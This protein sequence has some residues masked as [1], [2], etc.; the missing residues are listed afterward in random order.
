MAVGPSV[1]ERALAGLTIDALRAFG[2][3]NAPPHY[4]ASL[5]LS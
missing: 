2:N 4:P 5:V 1:S 3:P